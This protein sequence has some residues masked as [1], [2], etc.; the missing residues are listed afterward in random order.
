MLIRL[1]YMG[2]CDISLGKLR[3][4]YDLRLLRL[5]IVFIVPSV[6]FQLLV[7]DGNF[8]RNVSVRVCVELTEVR[9]I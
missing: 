5:N 1:E 2:K 4:K 7:V 8:F 9:L 3:N 6:E